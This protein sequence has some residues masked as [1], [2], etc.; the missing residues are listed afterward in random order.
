[1]RRFEAVTSRMARWVG[2]CRIAW[3]LSRARSDCGSRRWFESGTGSF[4]VFRRWIREGSSDKD[5][6]EPE[7]DQHRFLPVSFHDQIPSILASMDIAV[8]PLKTPF[9]VCA[10]EDL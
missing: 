9:R 3:L 6:P 8:V 2:L 5:G 4:R 10:L 1:M 7:A